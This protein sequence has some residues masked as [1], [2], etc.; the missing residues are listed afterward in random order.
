MEF[1]ATD[2]AGLLGGVVEGDKDVKVNDIS[3]IEAG[4]PGTLTFLANPKYTEYIYDTQASLAI[5][6]K[7]FAPERALPSTLTLIKVEDA[8]ASF[9]MVLEAYNTHKND[10][11]GISDKADI[12]PDATIGKDVFI[13]A[14]VSV[15][16][17]SVIGDGAKIY[18]NTTI[19]K[20]VHIGEGTVVHANCS[21]Y[22]GSRIGAHCRLH[23]QV[24]VGAD[25]FGFAPQTEEFKKV[26]QIGNVVIEDHVEIGAGTCIDRATFGSTF[27]RRGVKLDNLIQIAH[28]VDIGENTVIAAQTG[29]AGSTKVGKNVMMGG[30]V[31]V[32][33]HINIAD[34][35][36][37]AAQSG[38][39]HSIE[40]R[41]SDM[42]C[43]LKGPISFK[44]VGLHTGDDVELTIEPA[45]A[46][47]GYVFQRVDLPEK[48]LVPALLQNVVSTDR[49][50]TI[51]IGNAAISVTEHVLAALYGMGVDNVLLKIFGPEVPIMDGSSELFVREIER[52][53]VQE[54]DIPKDYIQ[55]NDNLLWESEEGGS[56]M[57][58]VPT[59]GGEFRITVMVDYR[60]PVLGTQ[61][62]SM[63]RLEQFKDEISPCR[64]FV[65]MK[66]LE[67]LAKNNLIKGGDL[68]NAIVLMEREYSSEEI[69]HILKMID[70]EELIGTISIEGIGV[71]NTIK[72]SLAS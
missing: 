28:N 67:V 5:V 35:S 9:A 10:E 29:I 70:R 25:G 64:T 60:S 15:G 27:I 20:D 30:Q 34:K 72:L 1:S 46:G 37:I 11:V 65:F 18:P 48:P 24:V 31:G 52:V 23:S 59:P 43:T 36:M 44:G 42:Q 32:I 61:H 22:Q 54:Q 7:T 12:A 62:A 71:L 14:F 47:H 38:I 41:I 4:R 58:A 45:A 56:E 57:M 19:A 17:G 6:S 68:D 2:I 50:T 21:I 26:A 55:L 63:Y 53:G 40:H 33:G 8:Y 66:E 39:G 51:A 16:A 13:A 69:S 49:G 3:K